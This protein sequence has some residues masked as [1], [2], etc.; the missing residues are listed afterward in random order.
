MSAPRP[1]APAVT[2]PLKLS[3]GL[4]SISY[5]VS[6]AVLS[7]SVLQLYFN[8]VIGIPGV[9][10]GAAIMLSL[11]VD[12]VVDP[13]IGRW[14]D[15]LRSGWGRRHPFMYGSAL[16]AA[17][18]FYL[19]WH[20]PRGLGATEAFTF[21]ILMLIGVRISLASYE[22]PSTALG[23]ELAPDYDQRTSLFAYRW[24]FMIATAAVMGMLL[25]S[26]FLRQDAA[27]PL[28]ALNRDGY[29]RFGTLSAGVILVAILASTAA[30]HNRIRG[31][32]RP[33]ARKLSVVETFREIAATF[34]NPSLLTIMGASVLGG[35]AYGITTGLSTYFYLHL[36]GLKPQAI[37]PLASGGLLASVIGVFLAPAIAKRFGKKEA[38]VGLF[39]VS[40]ATS[41]MPIAAR[42]V[43]IMPPNGSSALYALLFVDVV[44]TAAL[45]LM[46]YVILTS[47]T[48]DVVEDHAVKSGVRSEGVLFAANGLVPKITTGLGAFLAGLM[49]SLVKFPAHALPG[50]VGPAIVRHL[51]LIYLPAIALL[52]GS[53]IAVLN[54]YKIDRAT[55]ERNL[56]R[57]RDAAALAEVAG[58]EVGASGAVERVG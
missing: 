25:Y 52:S 10:V 2:L 6:L 9:W 22:I 38:M 4:G 34:A 15:N 12:A 40:L 23:P 50:T 49:I 8:Q 56:E 54:F 31:L 39:S 41:L 51:A 24:F 1:A 13:L 27:N 3:Y 7:A 53:S 37:G 44:V 19:L 43:G 18:F 42:M 11:C 47:M 45:A 26:V 16:P 14:S 28:G 20:A 57:L 36:W 48:A 5:G 55:H 32:H 35:A 58:L 46:A 30:T 33:P 29:A 21:A 17:G